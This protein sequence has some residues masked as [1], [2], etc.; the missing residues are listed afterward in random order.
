MPLLLPVTTATLPDWDIG[1]LRPDQVDREDE[2][3]IAGTRPIPLGAIAERRR[4]DHL[5]PP[6]DLHSQDALVESRDDFAGAGPEDERLIG[7]PVGVKLRPV[8]QRAH[9]V[10][11]DLRTRGDLGTGADRQIADPG[12]TGGPPHCREIDAQRRCEGR[13]R[14]LRRGAGAVGRRGGGSRGG[15]W[16]RRGGRSGALLT[17]RGSEEQHCQQRLSHLTWPSYS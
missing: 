12:P 3:R 2:N 13:L 1:L 9:V 5:A 6:A 16:G 15:S 11:G 10:N 7:R 8:G 17:A 4:D 14:K